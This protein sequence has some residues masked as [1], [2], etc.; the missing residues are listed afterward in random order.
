M[1]DKDRGLIWEAYHHAKEHK[2]EFGTGG[3]HQQIDD[4]EYIVYVDVLDRDDLEEYIPV[5]VKLDW[6]GEYEA[7]SWGHDGGSPGDAPMIDDVEANAQGD[8][9]S[10]LLKA[11]NKFVEDSLHGESPEYMNN[12]IGSGMIE[13]LPT[14]AG[15]VAQRGRDEASIDR[16]EFG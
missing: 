8:L 6:Y 3:D 5:K 12:L 11:I 4:D 1:K 10:N 13:D 2:F 16:Y 14:S 7:P 15:E 9:A